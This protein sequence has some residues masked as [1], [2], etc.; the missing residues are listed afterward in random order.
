[1]PH[2]T[3]LQPVKAPSTK[4]KPVKEDEA[5]D[6][7]DINALYAAANDLP[8]DDPLRAAPAPAPP[9]ATTE[10]AA[11]AQPTNSGPPPTATPSTAH[12]TSTSPPPNSNS[13]VF[14]DVSQL[15]VPSLFGLNVRQVI[16]QAGS[17]GLEVEIV[18]NGTARA[19]APAA[20]A[21]V[22]PGTKIVVRCERQSAF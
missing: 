15:R 13:V 18:G 11:P 6:V 14:A 8:S 5:S 16:E 1:V 17:A 12:S 20:G 3:D 2:D 19:Q 9:A 4:D 21:M 22:R 10:A 7:G